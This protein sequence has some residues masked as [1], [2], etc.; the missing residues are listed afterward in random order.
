VDV[1]NP[2]GRLPEVADVLCQGAVW[3]ELPDGLE[4]RV[5]SGSAGPME[6]AGTDVAAFS[7]RSKH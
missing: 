1:N 3:A 5:L 6:L 4:A 2:L 7:E